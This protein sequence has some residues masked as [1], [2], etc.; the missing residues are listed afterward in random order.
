MKFILIVIAC[1]QFQGTK[2]SGCHVV[3]RE[4]AASE[5][6]CRLLGAVA[7]ERFGV[8]PE[9]A[10]QV[11]CFRHREKPAGGGAGS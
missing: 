10:L 4:V 7:I 8:P 1:L 2:F 5:R 9:G 3:A 11:T 6:E